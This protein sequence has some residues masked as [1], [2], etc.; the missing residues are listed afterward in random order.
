MGDP[1]KLRSA[2]ENLVVFPGWIELLNG[3]KLTG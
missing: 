2:G 3:E 1:A